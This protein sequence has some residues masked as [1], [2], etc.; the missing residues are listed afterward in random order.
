MADHVACCVCAG[1]GEGACRGCIAPYLFL[2]PPL[3]DWHDL[4]EFFCLYL[5]RSWPL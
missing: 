3:A 5:N 1:N 4:N 2:F